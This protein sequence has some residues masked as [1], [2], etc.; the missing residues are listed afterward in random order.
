MLDCPSHMKMIWSGEE[1]DNEVVMIR[2][3]VQTELATE[4][5][6]S[7]CPQAKTHHEEGERSRKDEVLVC[8]TRAIVTCTCQQ[9]YS[10]HPQL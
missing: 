7:N 8:P 6:E 10:S 9:E 5:V 3:D 1:R 2:R 4:L